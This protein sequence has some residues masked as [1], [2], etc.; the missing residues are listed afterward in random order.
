MKT[1]LLTTL[2]A[3]QSIN[4][5]G[6]GLIF[7]AAFIATYIGLAALLVVAALLF[8][9]HFA[10]RPAVESQAVQLTAPQVSL[11]LPV[12]AQPTDQF[13]GLVV[14]EV[15]LAQPANGRAAKVKT[16]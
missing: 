9:M 4:P 15:K 5:L 14:R 7:T 3:I 13:A 12:A 6:A 8:G 16:V 10:K 2:A 1:N 11:P